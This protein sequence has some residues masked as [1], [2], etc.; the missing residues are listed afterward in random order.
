MLKMFEIFSFVPVSTTDLLIEIN[1][2]LPK[3]ELKNKSVLI[4][5]NSN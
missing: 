3:V 2:H 5:L 4:R 1:K